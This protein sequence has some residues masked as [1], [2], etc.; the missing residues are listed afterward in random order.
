MEAKQREM[1][2]VPGDGE[3]TGSDSG[4]G[5][6]EGGDSLSG[7]IPGSEREE[8]RVLSDGEKL[9]AAQG[10]RWE[11]SR[12]S[13]IRRWEREGIELSSVAMKIAKR[14]G[15]TLADADWLRSGLLEV[16]EDGVQWESRRQDRLR[17]AKV[18][19]ERRRKVR[20]AKP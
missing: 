4:S 6:E 14:L 19:K 20:E 16:F 17:Y 18:A 1:A 7:R 13:R 8:V 2:V 5:A 12:L 11:L 3:G 15:G 10:E 9:A